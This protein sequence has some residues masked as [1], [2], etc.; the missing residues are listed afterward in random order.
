MV[1][2][3]A[4]SFSGSIWTQSIQK[5]KEV[6]RLCK[7]NKCFQYSTQCLMTI[8]NLVCSEFPIYLIV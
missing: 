5:Q 1:A 8:E 2:L 7:V 6:V 4:T 3:T